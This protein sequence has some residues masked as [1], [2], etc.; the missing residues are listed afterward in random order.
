MVPCPEC[1]FDNP[2]TNKFCGE[3][4]TKLPVAAA[5]DL[6]KTVTIVFSDITDS[7][8]LGEGLDPEILRTVM[9]RYFDGMRAV[10]ERHDGT[11]EKFI[12]DAVMAVFGIPV[13]H[14]DDALRAVRAA[15]EMQQAVDELSSDLEERWG[16]RIKTRTG[17]NT[18]EVM[19]GDATSGEALVTGDAVNVAA[20]LEQSAEPGQI[21]I[22]EGTYRLVRHA[23]E[24]GEAIELDVKG[25]TD[26]VTA[27]PLMNLISD[28]ES[29]P[30]RG[31]AALVGRDRERELVL[32]AFQEA[33]AGDSCRLVTIVGSPGVGKSR[34][35]QE[36]LTEIGDRAV[37]LSGRCLSYGQGITYWP[38][39]EIIKQAAGVDDIERSDE[40]RL[41]LSKL[42]GGE[43]SELLSGVLANDEHASRCLGAL[44]GLVD[45]EHSTEETTVAV[46]KLLEDLAGRR[47]L[48][49][50]FD[51]IHWA[52]QTFLDTI[53]YL[54]AWVQGPVL[55]LCMA[56]PELVDVRPD[57]SYSEGNASS[58]QLASLPAE[59]AAEMISSILT[60]AVDADLKD[61]IIAAADGNPLFVEELIS[62]LVDDGTLERRGDQ[63]AVTDVE[64]IAIPPTVQSLLAARIDG[65]SGDERALMERAAIVGQEFERAA[66]VGLSEEE[67]RSRVSSL[68]LRLVRRELIRPQ[69]GSVSQDDAYAFRHLLIRD[70]AYNSMPK[71]ARAELHERFARWLEAEVGDE[72]NEYEEILG[73][74]YE[75][76]WNYLRD[77]AA[78]RD[79]TDL[80]D[81]AAYFLKNSGE[82]A[83]ARGD[84]RATV[85]LLDRATSLMPEA[86]ESR[87]VLCT[88]LA[89]ALHHAGLHTK[90][91]ELL[92]H[93]ID[94]S[95]R[96]GLERPALRATVVKHEWFA[97]GIEEGIRPIRQALERLEEIGTTADVLRA[98]I[99][100]GWYDF[101]SGHA[102]EAESSLF[103]ALNEAV[104]L[105]SPLES[106][107]VGA[108][109]LMMQFG[110]QPVSEALE[111]VEWIEETCRPSGR[112]T[113][114]TSRCRAALYGLAGR[115]DEARSSLAK[116]REVEESIG[117][118][119]IKAGTVMEEAEIEIRAL[120]AAEAAAKIEPGFETLRENGAEVLVPSVGTLLGLMHARAGNYERAE[121]LVNEGRA[122]T[123]DDD[124]E[125][126]ARGKA[127]LALCLAGRGEIDRAIIE[128]EEAHK[129]AAPTD[130][131]TF[132]GEILVCKADVF[133]TAG[134]PA[135]AVAALEE[136]QK[137]FER[138]E[139]VAS[140]RLVG[141]RLEQL[142]TV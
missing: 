103:A 90:C 130:Y 91:R 39:V 104:E 115:F 8:A 125:V 111:R 29:H 23:I 26:P 128:V 60:G 142:S 49:V 62:M 133:A 77:L 50:V 127:A 80:R 119:A 105:S 54:A 45:E 53:Q 40:S 94:V 4:G 36:A 140:V 34:L 28:A 7:T 15:L 14:E 132:R 61:R 18:G 64:Q 106:E 24:A 37:V 86:D 17:V 71:Q 122:A 92:D 56:R 30:R 67:R 117:A 21:L 73:Y 131:L 109:V 44:V 2:S 84:A 3:C 83:W 116:A 129:I 32:G 136:A 95:R 43:D 48:V 102:A 126:H 72:K 88:V 65:L 139:D 31:V 59:A 27:R 75:A 25:K 20:R 81:R 121:Q 138:K 134:R 13:L 12:G 10:I 79:S 98:R 85:S 47:P 137:L 9:S 46:R 112:I 55:L 93:V 100:L 76:A 68:L 63:W 107:I 99:A 1:G 120:P 33:V 78:D 114:S 97:G 108:L 89:D 19:T 118:L 101:W 74:H 5:R 69:R 35:V 22:G 124:F 11:V 57:W 58:V 52:E 51:D 96:E 16:V 82:R 38:I 135:D 41:K 42:L 66:V 70:A 6:R 141:A 110:P 123:P 87:L 113:S